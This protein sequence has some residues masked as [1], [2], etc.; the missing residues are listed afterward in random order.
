MNRHEQ[1]ETDL[2]VIGSG[3]G[4]AVTGVLAAKSGR[5]VLIVEEGDDVPLTATPHF[6]REEMLLKYR[7]A[8]VSV[9][10]GRHK[11]AWVE[12]RCVGGGSEVNRGLY[13]RTPDYLLEAWRRDYRV[14]DLKPETMLYHFEACEAIARVEHVPGTPSEMSKKLYKGALAKG[15]HAIE[16][17]RLYRYNSKSTGGEKQSMSVTFIRDFIEA[18]GTLKTGVRIGRL[19]RENRHWIAT[20][21]QRNGDGTITAI[22]IRASSVVVACGAVQTPALLRRS[23]FNHNIGNSLRFH[24][25]VKVVAE[26]DHDINSPDDPDPVH[27]IKEFEP[28]LGMGC[29]ISAPPMLG[30]ALAGRKAQW[31]L[32]EQRW[33]RMG[34]Y[35]VQSGGGIASVRNVPGYNDPIVRVN[36]SHADLALLGKGLRHLGEVLFAAGAMRIY[37]CASGYPDLETTDD[38]GK[39]PAL[40]QPTDGTLTSVHI[41]SS[42]PMGEDTRKTATNSFGKVHHTDGLYVNDAS[43]L[44]TPTMVNPQGTVTA[45]AH[46]NVLEALDR[47][48]R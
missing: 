33:R 43:L 27:Q 40:L 44:C 25:M 31:H 35:Y 10:L 20:G 11:V 38:L 9:A 39:L 19:R 18:G 30:V 16:A 36:F 48:F 1:I 2:L 17:P 37:P 8:G 41:F 29:S 26:F 6:S 32:V 34:I 22:A 13:H 15:W 4:G 14:D 42:C 3:P 47:K 23:G 28:H 5:G 12:G 7:N 24:P 46:R 45:I 21:S